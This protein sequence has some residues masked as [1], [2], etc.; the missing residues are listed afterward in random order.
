MIAA[1]T[2]LTGGPAARAARAVQANAV[3]ARVPEAPTTQPT[4]V[5]PAPQPHLTVVSSENYAS[6]E[7]VL[8]SGL[9]ERQVNDLQAQG[10][11]APEI[12][13]GRLSYTSLDLLVAQRAGVLLTQGVAVRQLTPLRRLVQLELDFVRDITV[14]LQSLAKAERQVQE[15]RVAQEVS[16]LRDAVYSATVAKHI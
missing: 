7:F 13:N 5:A 1:E 14:P 9:S 15:A 12:I 10:F 4:P 11:L 3:S 16:A 8:A 2:A 6:E